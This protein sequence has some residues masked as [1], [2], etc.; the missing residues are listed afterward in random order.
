M[1]SSTSPLSLL[2]LSCLS[3]HCQLWFIQFYSCPWTAGGAKKKKKRITTR[4]IRLHFT[5]EKEGLKKDKMVRVGMQ[6]SYFQS[7][8]NNAVALFKEGIH[9]ELRV[10]N[11]R[12]QLRWNEKLKPLP[13]PEKCSEAQSRPASETPDYTEWVWTLKKYIRE[14]HTCRRRNW[15][16]AKTSVFTWTWEEEN[17]FILRAGV[18]S[19]FYCNY[20]AAHPT[21]QLRSCLTRAH[22]PLP[23]PSHN[24]RC[25]CVCVKYLA[26]PTWWAM[27]GKEGSM[28]EGGGGGR[29]VR[30]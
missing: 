21:C 3:W 20:S 22:P 23:H 12:C 24:S 4:A 15:F 26:L 16:L 19:S 29:Q 6:R 27:S 7:L 1:N 2:S 10:M 18:K 5:Q 30:K 17:G 11:C 8:N 25:M 14:D 13:L 28:G 9:T